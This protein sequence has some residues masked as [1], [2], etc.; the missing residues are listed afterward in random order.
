MAWAGPALTIAIVKSRPQHR[1][2]RGKSIKRELDLLDTGD[3]RR[4]EWG[5]PVSRE[6]GRKSIKEDI[7]GGDK[8]EEGEG[9]RAGKGKKERSQASMGWEGRLIGWRAGMVGS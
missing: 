7:R 2:T 1:I 6:E 9:R 4:L 8:K 3:T 5:K